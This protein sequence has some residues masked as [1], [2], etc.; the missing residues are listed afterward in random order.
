MFPR[1]RVAILAVALI[2]GVLLLYI[3]LSLLPLDRR[4]GDALMPLMACSGALLFVTGMTLG[5][6]AA[7]YLIRRGDGT[8]LLFDPPQQLVVAGPY[9]HLQHPLLLGGLMMLSGEAL[10]LHSPSVGIYA[11]A[12]A[13]A[14]HAY[15]VW[16]EEPWLIQKF[17]VDYRAYRR[18][19]PRWL[20]QLPTS[21]DDTPQ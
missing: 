3:P 19:V 15:V 11:A 20:P 4:L 13:L 8:P 16:V 21:R 7:Y 9:A 14:S 17:G 18:A 2:L 5:F 1:R 12:V 6:S 10:W